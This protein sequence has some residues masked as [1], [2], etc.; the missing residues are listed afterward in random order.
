VR[1]QAVQAGVVQERESLGPEEVFVFDE[2][3]P[4][5]QGGDAI[6][7][8]ALQHSLALC[9]WHQLHAVESQRRA[10]GPRRE[11]SR[12]LAGIARAHGCRAFAD[13]TAS[14]LCLVRAKASVQSHSQS[15]QV[16]KHGACVDG[17]QLIGIA[18]QQQH[19]I[20]AQRRAAVSP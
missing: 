19:G 18:Q 9:A 10:R 8:P 7:V 15:S 11:Q 4:L 2:L 14:A 17:R 6:L 12:Q 13:A 5:G 16:A 20:V 1:V 3:V